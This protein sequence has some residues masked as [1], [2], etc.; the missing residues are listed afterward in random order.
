MAL[1]SA[2]SRR[3]GLE[4]EQMAWNGVRASK[5]D[6]NFQRRWFT[7]YL[8]LAASRP[9]LDHLAALLEGKGSTEGMDINQDLRWQI[10]ALLNRRNYPGSTAMVEAE[11]ARDKSDRGAAA[12]VAAAAGRPDS[13]TKAEW[14]ATVHDLKTKLPFS[15]VR[16]AMNNLYPA[17]Q[18]GLSEQTAEARLARLPKVDQEAGPVFMRSYAQS[19]IPVAC[20]PHS[21]KR[22]ADANA[23]IK[24]LSAG[25]RR[26]LQDALQEDQRCVAIKQALTVPKA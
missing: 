17:G 2:W 1:D 5:G 19:M 4:L 16:T 14:L 3:T 12:A 11:M 7:L 18:T 8:S 15:K 23:G 13:R 26:A 9:A 25:T 20:T 22:L 6:D 10:I 21:V 24:N